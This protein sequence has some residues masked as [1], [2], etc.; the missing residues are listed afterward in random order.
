M[1]GMMLNWGSY[2]NTQVAQGLNGAVGVLNAANN[3]ELGDRSGNPN[4]RRVILF[5]TDTTTDPGPDTGEPFQSNTVG[6]G[7]GPANQFLYAI[8]CGANSFYTR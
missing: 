4:Y 6:N 8:F 3:S 2:D 5:V 7:A 1:I